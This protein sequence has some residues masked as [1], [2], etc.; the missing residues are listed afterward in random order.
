MLYTSHTIANE[1]VFKTFLYLLSRPCIWKYTLPT[2]LLLK[3]LIISTKDVWVDVS[4][5]TII[6]VF[7]IGP[8][9][10]REP[11]HEPSAANK[12]Y[13]RM[14]TL[15]VPVWHQHDRRISS[16][17]RECPV[18]WS[19]NGWKSHWLKFAS[20]WKPWRA[21]KTDTHVIYAVNEAVVKSKIYNKVWTSNFSW[22]IASVFWYIACFKSR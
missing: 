7:S 2:F 12:W 11:L 10:C 3:S 6:H 5:N 19:G 9:R 21:I 14:R 16:Y 18:E 1:Y 4:V 13:L 8:N 22:G 17:W 15:K 20:L